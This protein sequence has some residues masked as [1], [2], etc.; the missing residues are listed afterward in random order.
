MSN[1]KFEKSIDYRNHGFTAIDAFKEQSRETAKTKMVPIITKVGLPDYTD[2]E[3]AKKGGEV[4]SYNLNK[5]MPWD[6]FLKLGRDSQKNY[7]EGIRKS[8]KGVTTNDIAQ[9]FGVSKSDVVKV[10]RGIGISFGKGGRKSDAVRIAF[11]RDMLGIE[12]SYEPVTEQIPMPTA[13]D[14]EEGLLP[15][16]FMVESAVVVCDANEVQDAIKTLR[17]SG[18]VRVSIEVYERD[19]D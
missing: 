1:L 10:C 11:E 2:K 19:S 9:M 6:D 13:T 8:Y 12:R 15:N 5:P 18:L 4:V 7:I 17:F 14:K 3:L 16:S